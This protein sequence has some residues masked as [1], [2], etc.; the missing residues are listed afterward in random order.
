MPNTKMSVI[1]KNQIQV[2]STL[3]ELNHVLNW[4][5]QLK[6]PIVPKATWMQCQTALAEGFTNAV[7]HAH[8]YHSPETLIE[9]EV[10]IQVRSLEIRIWDH[11][12]VFDLDQK[13]ETLPEIANP[14]AIGGRGLV[15]LH[16]VADFLSYT[17]TPDQRNCLLIIK[18]Y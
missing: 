8:K 9:I 14:E 4:F 6:Q 11:G 13:L 15:L 5:N 2:Q 17:R 3:T 18:N 10:V 1:S 12:A 7:R 16:R